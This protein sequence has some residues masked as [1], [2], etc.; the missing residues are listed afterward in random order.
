MMNVDLPLENM[1]IAEKLHTMELL[2]ADLSAN[3]R[4]E[5]TPSWHW[6]VLAN[7][8]QRLASGEEKVLDWDEAKQQL[9]KELN[10]SSNS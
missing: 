8:E 3:A 2:W 6:D 7:R 5:V 4:E 9:R 1:T 10:D